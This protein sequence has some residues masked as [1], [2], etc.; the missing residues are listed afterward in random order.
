MANAITMQ[1]L[2]NASVDVQTLEQ[3]VNGDNNTDVTSRLGNTYPTL[4]KAL[5]LI[6]Q[7]GLVGST[8]YK[9]YA[10]LVAAK[11][12]VGTYGVVT[13]D[14]D[15]SKNGLYLNDNGTLKYSDLN[16]VP[17]LTREL[18]KLISEQI[19]QTATQK[20]NAG[21]DIV[22][23]FADSD[24]KTAVN[25]DSLGNVNASNISSADDIAYAYAVVD[26][27]N[28]VAF[29][30][31]KN[32]NLVSPTIDSINAN[33][34]KLNSNKI[35][36][37]QKTDYM[38][39]FSYGQ[40]LSRGATARPIISTSQPYNN[41][42]FK[43]GV[44][45]RPSEGIDYS[46]FIPLV[47]SDNGYE[48]ET[49][50][51]GF[52][53]SFVARKVTNG[54]Q[55]SSWR[56]VGSAP[57]MVGYDIDSLDKN[58][59]FYDYLIGQVQGGYD[60]AQSKNKSYSVWSI[61]YTQGEQD[62]A[63]NTSYDKY[64]SMLMTLISN[65]TDDIKR[66]T[67]QPFNPV[68]LIYQT[69]SHRIYNR[70]TMTIAQA[71]LDLA[72]SSDVILATPIYQLPKSNDNLHLT[73]DSSNQLG[74]YYAKA[75]E[76]TQRTGQKFEPLKPISIIAQGKIIDITFNKHDLT[77]DTSLLNTAKNMGFDVWV[78]DIVQDIISSVTITDN[79]RVRI[80]LSSNIPINATLSYAKGRSGDTVSWGNLRDND[81]KDGY[82]DSQGNKRYLNNWCVMFEQKIN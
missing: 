73:A 76:F 3:V 34:Q 7:H 45:K 61:A 1:Q 82:L 26:D 51:S 57:G 6:M 10:D 63:I 14:S 30:I 70:N 65:L 60:V 69:A 15:P 44:L 81:D 13:N 40:S 23:A 46:D 37:L 58:T 28:K 4:D 80:V 52:A 66:I 25:F 43:S 16:S 49:P 32:G 68:F 38:H 72:N 74:R 62:Y 22:F 9:T 56:F 29:A 42:T 27:D 11:I 64:K 17:Y 67:K 36:D 79:N 41:V 20:T 12:T 50:I 8:P 21:N 2:A 35:V 55:A 19:A 71:Q 59:A 31:D 54:E 78:G 18:N 77:F 48:G 53:N 75:L 33:L 24:N 47:E 5:K 39:L